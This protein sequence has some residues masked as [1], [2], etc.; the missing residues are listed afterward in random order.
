MY[1][2]FIITQ[3]KVILIVLVKNICATI[4]KHLETSEKNTKGNPTNLTQD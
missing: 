2:T 1:L 3:I 4:V